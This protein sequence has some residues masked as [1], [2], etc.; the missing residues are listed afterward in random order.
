MLGVATLPWELIKDPGRYINSWLGGYGAALGSIA[1]VLI[2]DYWILKKTG[3][4][5]RSLYVPD[6]RYRYTN[7]WNMPAVIAT[8][9]RLGDRAGRRVLGTD[10][11]AVRLLV[12]RRLRHRR[13]CITR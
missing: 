6:G 1:G 8:P 11:L 5:L 13:G 3:L 4:D 2:V 10:A 12:V 9:R 7:G